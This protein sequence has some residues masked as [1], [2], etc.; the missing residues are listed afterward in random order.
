VPTARASR[1]V[2]GRPGCCATDHCELCPIDAKGTA[3]NTVYPAIKERIDLRAGLLATE[4]HCRRGRIDAV[5]ALDAK[6][7]KHRL[8]AREFIVA[9]NGVDSCLL[10][11]RSPTMPQLPSLGRY[12]MDQTAFELAI[13]D[14]G[15]DARP[16]YGDSAETGMLVTFFE[17]VDETLPVSV[18]GEIRPGSFAVPAGSP[19]RD[20]L[21]R[22]LIQHALESREGA[23]FHARFNKA[24][25]GSVDLLFMI[26]SQPLADHTV[27]ID[28]IEPS[29][30]AVPR[31]QLQYPTYFRDCVTRIKG[32]LQRRAPRAV[33]KH[34]NTFPSS[35]HWLGATRMA[36]SD[37]EGCVDAS[38]RYHSVENL[39]ILS[40]S[41]YPSSSSANPTLTLA[42]LALRLGDHLSPTRPT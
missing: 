39:H 6:G 33:I 13:Y 4:L 24:W 7:H 10:L 31:F 41:V 16:G 14:S 12:Y 23:D 35:F 29:G 38:L 9:C 28:R 34:V 20:R 25:S 2:D 15:V 18:L 27:A 21:V 11:Q 1:P 8:E 3:L 17:R 22:D 36:S 26:E 40:T 37:A 42:A 32:H 30:Q 5:T 19:S